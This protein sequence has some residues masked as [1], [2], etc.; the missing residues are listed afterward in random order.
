MENLWI[1]DEP[2]LGAVVTRVLGRAAR[3]WWIVAAV[4]IAVTALAVFVRARAMPRN[5]FTVYFNLIEGGLT[6]A[7]EEV[8]PPRDIRQYI[9]NVALSRRQVEA[10]MRK[11]GLSVGWLD[12]DPA[13]A[14]EDFRDKISITVTRNYF[15]YE[16]GENDPPRS[17]QVSISLEGSDREQVHLLLGEIREAILRDQRQR[18]QQL[19]EV[20]SLF[21]ARLAEA[22]KRARALQLELERLS[23]VAARGDVLERIDARGR[24]AAVRAQTG[25]AI[26]QVVVLERAVA[27][28]TF[29]RSAERN[30]LGLTLEV[31]DERDV[32]HAPR[33]TTAQ[34]ARRAAVVFVV[35][36]VLTALSVGAFDG[37]IYVP[38]DVSE[39][40]VTALGALPRFDGDDVGAFLAREK[41]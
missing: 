22:R 24:M 36:A 7:D 34:H 4:T 5:E 25:G 13:A 37:R 14:I 35:A 38:R 8:Q 26:D 11:H 12:R 10:M 21:E 28:V 41:A 9:A 20:R 1:S 3:R 16:R 30:Q 29:N 23:D 6:R 15:L 31:V 27:A 40:G 33:L 17:A 32:T 19:E 2:K 39:A 18:A